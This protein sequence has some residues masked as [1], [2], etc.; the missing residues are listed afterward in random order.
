MK[1]ATT[2]MEKAEQ[3]QQ[4]NV[5]THDHPARPRSPA[6]LILLAICG[7]LLFASFV[8]LGSWQIKRLY[9][10]RALIERVAQRVNAPAV[11]APAKIDWPNITPETD[12]YRHVRV[13]GIFLNHLS[14]RVQ[15]STVLGRGFWLITPLQTADN[16]IILINRGYIPY[17]TAHPTT[18]LTAT[19]AI[20][21]TGLLRMSEAGGAFL[22]RNNP[23]EQRWYS[24]DVPA[25]A[26]AL[27][28]SG[29]A[30]YF[31]DADANTNAANSASDNPAPVGGLTV[32]AFNNNHLVYT[33]TWF[34]L[35]LMVAGA[36]LILFRTEFRLRRTSL[37]PDS[38]PENNGDD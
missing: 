5:R 22:R 9:W 28:L 38:N 6:K 18:E 34:A 31:I 19:S 25:M 12:E 2:E 32:I 4:L 10:K 8:A 21:V 17:K 24:R 30:P 14:I 35:A 3:N 20:E 16:S 29:V 37:H 15:A 26:A 36:C 27:Q 1:P 11:T 33:L 7:A 23:N 13:S